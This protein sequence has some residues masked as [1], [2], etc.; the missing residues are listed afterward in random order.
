MPVKPQ[1]GFPESV[2]D[3]DTIQ[4]LVVNVRV[5]VPELLE[6]NGVLKQ[7]GLDEAL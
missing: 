3:D 1:A 7:A 5:M 6:A 2:T 4:Q